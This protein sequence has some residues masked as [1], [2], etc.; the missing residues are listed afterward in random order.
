MSEIRVPDGGKI[1][2]AIDR[3]NQGDIGALTS[4]FADDVA[5]CSPLAGDDAGSFWLQGSQEVAEHFLSMRKQF[6][7]IELVEVLAGAG[8]TNMLLRHPGGSISLL[9]EPDEHRRARR[10]IACHSISVLNS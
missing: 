10:I 3:W 2:L 1:A 7:E 5:Y 9:I 4:M 8:F 6:K